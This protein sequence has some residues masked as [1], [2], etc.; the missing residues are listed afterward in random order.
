MTPSLRTSRL[1]LVHEMAGRKVEEMARRR[2][3]PL[4]GGSL[5]AIVLAL[6]TLFLVE[7]GTSVDEAPP[8]HYD[9]SLTPPPRDVRPGDRWNAQITVFRNGRP[10]KPPGKAVPL[11]TV[12]NATTGEWTTRA[13]RPTG[14]PGIYRTRVVFRQAGEYK[15][16]VLFGDE[17]DS[18]AVPPTK[19]APPVNAADDSLRRPIGLVLLVIA[20][21][22]PIVL[23]RRYPIAVLAV[24]LAA[25]LAADIAYDNFLFAGPLVALYTVAA[26]V[27]R[28]RSLQAAGATAVALALLVLGVSNLGS[29]EALSAFT[30]FG[31]A[32]LLGDNL[33]TRR[34]RAA[35]LEAE[36][37]ANVKRATA[38][39][40]ARIGREVHDIVGHSVSVMT[41]QASAAGDAFDQR[42]AQVREALRAIETTGRET[43]AE[44]RRLLGGV[45]PDDA[46]FAPVPGLAGLDALAE[47]VRSAGLAVELSAE[48]LAEPLPPSVDLTAYRI[49][50]EALTNT[51]KHAHAQHARV[52]VRRRN[53]ALEIEVVDD[54]RAAAS[55]IP[56]HGIIGMKERAALF[57]GDLTAGPAPGGGFAVR[58]RIPVE[59]PA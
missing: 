43:L 3:L 15:Y 4:L 52:D 55:G 39:E 44:L 5:F 12:Q 26:H 1:L 47:R 9:W 34:E 57:G 20:S 49:V 41:I 13:A 21:T 48:Q 53:G 32:W 10:A 54:G 16:A 25:A 14:A 22:L 58:A 7:P 51:L 28:P 18:V 42:P 17:F 35:R 56:G 23:R 37:Q 46:A 11:L 27:G 38:E 19:P 59:E 45:R 2:P 6:A 24:T 29:W 31:A 40:Q 36:R 50:Q 33:R 30:A 8:T